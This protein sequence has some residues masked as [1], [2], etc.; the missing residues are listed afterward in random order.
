[1]ENLK[2]T[3]II[4]NNRGLNLDS[5]RTKATMD[6][7]FFHGYTDYGAENDYAWIGVSG[8]DIYYSKHLDNDIYSYGKEN[9]SIAIPGWIF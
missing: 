6:N 8:D 5:E 4:F 3:W 1:M 7:N 2:L 9:L